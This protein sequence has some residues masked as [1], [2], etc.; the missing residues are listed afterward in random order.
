V[1]RVLWRMSQDH[2][3]GVLLQVSDRGIN[4][5]RPPESHERGFAVSSLDLLSG[6]EV[7]EEPMDSLPGEL[8]DAFGKVV[9]SS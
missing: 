5:Y 4:P 9:S 7:T 3:E 6:V 2:P 1:P 8:T